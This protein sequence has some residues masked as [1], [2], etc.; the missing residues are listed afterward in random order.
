MIIV[1]RGSPMGR[2]A[3]VFEEEAVVVALAESHEIGVVH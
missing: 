3:D 1:A 2:D